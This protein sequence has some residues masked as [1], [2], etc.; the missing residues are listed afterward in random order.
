METEPKVETNR[1]NE[2]RKE[3]RIWLGEAEI[4]IQLQQAE[5]WN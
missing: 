2:T 4:N 5:G 3:R 1:R